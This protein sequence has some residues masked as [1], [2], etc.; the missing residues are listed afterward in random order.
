MTHLKLLALAG[1]VASIASATHA[2]PQD[3]DVFATLGALDKVTGRV[4][5]IQAHVGKPVGFGAIEV[6]LRDCASAPPEEAPETKAFVEIRDKQSKTVDDLVFSGWMFASSPALVAL[7]HP[8]YDIWVLK[9]SAIAPFM[10]SLPPPAEPV[11][12][13]ATSFDELFPAVEDGAVDPSSVDP[14]S[15]DSGSEIQSVPEI[16]N[17]LSE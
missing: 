8:I 5:Q 10:P 3:S 13:G 16:E 2:E 14:S 1:V 4:T 12:S 17:N 6:T 15:V 9:C 7:E 11:K